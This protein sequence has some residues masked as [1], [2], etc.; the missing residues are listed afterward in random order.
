MRARVC[1]CV[2]VCVCVCV[3][4]CVGIGMVDSPSTDA[5]V[6]CLMWGKLRNCILATFKI[7]KMR[8][9]LKSCRTRKKVAKLKK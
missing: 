4:V 2:F 8:L 9:P 5:S 1:V 3:C 6:A 7:R